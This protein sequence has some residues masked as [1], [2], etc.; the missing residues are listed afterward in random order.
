MM[1]ELARL[2][3]SSEQRV[4][5]VQDPVYLG[6]LNAR[7]AV[8]ARHS[9]RVR[10]LRRAVPAT[11]AAAMLVVAGLSIFNP[12]R[13][14]TKLPFDVGSVNV[15]GTKIT[16]QA[17]R[18][19]GFTADGRPY[20]VH[21]RAALQDVTNP[22]FM[23]LED[24]RGQI[25]MEDMSMLTLTSRKGMM[26]GKAQTLD[27]GEKIVLKSADYEARLTEVHIDMAKGD[28]V[29]D[30]PVSVSFRNGTLDA[31]RLE[32]I[33]SGALFR[34]TGGVRMNLQPGEAVASPPAQGGVR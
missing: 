5:S 8:A 10:M 22:S 29:S 30:K 25:Q 6:S 28:V 15:S 32:I 14:L 17:P 26:D 12:F 13:M 1:L 34:F 31:Q 3:P 2:G 27:L 9:R 20:E 23:E 24:I 4:V 33:D 11:I 18:L 21:A 7:F 19:A 16:M